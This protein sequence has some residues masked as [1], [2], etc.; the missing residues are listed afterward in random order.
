MSRPRASNPTGVG[1]NWTLQFAD[2]FNGNSLDTST[3]ATSS[4]AESDDGR[5]NKGNQQLEWNQ[6]QNCSVG[7][8]QL[9]ITAKPDNI[10]SPSGQHYSWSSCLITSSPSYAFQHGFIEERAKL[11]SNKGF[12]AAF[13]TWP[14]RGSSGSETDAYE[15]YSNNHSEL[16]LSH[17]HVGGCIFRPNFDPSTGFH[18]YGVDIESGNTTWYV[19]GVKACTMSGSSSGPTNIID[20]MFVYS[21]IPPSSGSVEHKIIDYIRAWQH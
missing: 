2:D 9:T 16:H 8:G 6:P 12:W 11:P 4:S 7:G 18:T 20:D 19:D 13:W 10:T 15:Y 21:T 3:W 14:A 17:P 5:G 1:G